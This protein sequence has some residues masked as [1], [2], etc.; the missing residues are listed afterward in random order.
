MKK[1]LFT[2]SAFSFAGLLFF[3]CFSASNAQENNAPAIKMKSDFYSENKVITD[4]MRFEGIEYYD[5]KFTG[6]DLNHKEYYIVAKEIWGGKIK[7]IDTVFN[8]ATNNY[9][10]KISSDSLNL[11]V[12][13]GKSSDKTLKIKFMFDRFEIEKEYK[14]TDSNDYSLRDFGTHFPII[15]EK[16]FYAFAYI[17][18]Y[19]DKE[20]NKYWCAVESSGKDIETW[21]KEFGIKHYILFEMNFANSQ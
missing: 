1:N 6:Q 4:I 12:I 8:S 14:S 21:G 2:T 7:K 13:A 16:P 10:E 18:P 9:I 19:E 11:R 15:P 5:T 20:G 17:L 3:L